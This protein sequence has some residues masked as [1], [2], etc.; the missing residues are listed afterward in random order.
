MKEEDQN[1]RLVQV[2]SGSP[3]ET[4]LVKGLLESNGVSSILKDGDIAAL[5]PYYPGQEVAILVNES[6]YESAMEVIRDR[7]KSDD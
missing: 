5:A 4:E 2:F 1:T 6:N 3:W 7:V